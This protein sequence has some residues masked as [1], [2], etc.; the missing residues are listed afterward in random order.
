MPNCPEPAGDINKFIKCVFEMCC[1]NF[2][3]AA[4]RHEATTFFP[5]LAS[6]SA[7]LLP[8]GDENAAHELCVCPRVQETQ[9][10]MEYFKWIQKQI[11][12]LEKGSLRIQIFN[13]S[14]FLLALKENCTTD[15]KN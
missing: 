11:I 2:K 13:F 3:A 15:Q 7:C 1:E 4:R 6:P 5:S 14:H 8:K 9:V 10:V 12:Y